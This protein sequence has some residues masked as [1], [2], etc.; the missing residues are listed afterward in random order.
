MPGKILGLDISEDSITAVQVKSE[1]KGYQ[2]TAFARVMVEE[3]G[4][5]DNALRSLFNQ[6]DLTSDTYLSSIPGEHVS[7]RNL[8]MPFK[9]PKK[10]R[11][12]IAF[13][14]ES[15][16]PFPIEDVVVDFTI[17]DQAGQSEILAALVSRRYITYRL[18]ELIP[19]FWM[20]GLCLWSYGC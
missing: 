10:I 2:I 19:R 3:E 1:L 4:G 12:T 17:I 15:M 5:L 16:I 14:L 13:E 11:Q 6:M 9:E 18:M 7:Y 20:L 8:Q